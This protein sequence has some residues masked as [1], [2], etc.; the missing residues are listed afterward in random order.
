MHELQVLDDDRDSRRDT[1]LLV[2]GV[3]LMVVGAGLVLSNR[4]VRRY[5]DR[6]GVADLVLAAFP[7]LERFLKM[8]AM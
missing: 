2:G 8:R 1:M 3:A 5:I 6:V 4:S 7:D